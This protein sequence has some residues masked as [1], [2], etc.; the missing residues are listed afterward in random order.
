L[1][2]TARRQDDK[3]DIGSTPRHMASRDK[4]SNHGELLTRS[5]NLAIALTSQNLC[6]VLFHVHSSSNGTLAL[7]EMGDLIPRR[8]IVYAFD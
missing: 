6:G 8:C 4:R 3:T 1:I 7:D 5:S 2:V